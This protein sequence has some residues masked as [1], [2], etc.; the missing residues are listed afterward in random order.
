M[1]TSYLYAAAAAITFFWCGSVVAISFLEAW[2]K[3]SAP[4]VTLPIGLGIGRLVFS[5]LNKLEWVLLIAGTVCGLIAGSGNWPGM[6][7]L[8]LA[9]GI[10]LIE[11][12]WLLPALD[13][14]AVAYMSGQ[15]PGPSSTHLVFIAAEL[16]KVAGLIL[17]GID[18][19]KLVKLA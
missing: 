10:L 5:A 2:L 3:F 4:G 19:L 8:F 14:R 11:T 18:L 1:T 6:V 7:W 12:V 15:Q 9:A 13:K 16:I 17:A